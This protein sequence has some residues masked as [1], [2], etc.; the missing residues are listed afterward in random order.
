M[1]S[2]VNVITVETLLASAWREL[3]GEEP[4]KEQVGENAGKAFSFRSLTAA[5][6]QRYGL[7]VGDGLAWRLGRS[8]FQEWMRQHP[9]AESLRG[10]AFRLLPPDDR[11]ERT[12]NRFFQS[13]GCNVRIEILPDAAW[14]LQLDAPAESALFWTGA[15]DAML[16]ALSGD[17]IWNIQLAHSSNAQKV[18]LLI[19]ASPFS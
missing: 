1:M 11:K 8:F 14:L 7:L 18:F 4:E 6:R 17:K 16:S 5:L 3:L 15:V 2:A 13:V 10:L 9:D 19:P 12:L